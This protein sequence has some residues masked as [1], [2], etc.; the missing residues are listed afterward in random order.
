MF[1]QKQNKNENHLSSEKIN[2]YHAVNQIRIVVRHQSYLVAIR[3]FLAVVHV[4][5]YGRRRVT[6]QLGDVLERQLGYEHQ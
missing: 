6:V 4:Y 1:L 5:P 2:E 3:M